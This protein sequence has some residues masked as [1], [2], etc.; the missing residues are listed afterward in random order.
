MQST[1]LTLLDRLCGPVPERSAWERFVELYTPLLGHWARQRGF[2]A[3]DAE[4]L[5]QELFV[6]LLRR[7]PAYERREAGS[8]RGWL[9]Y[10]VRTVAGQ[11]RRARA[12]RPLPT[13]SPASDLEEADELSD[14]EE[15]EFRKHLV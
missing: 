13:R 7:L 14:M 11:F 10:E 5:V 6:R 15:N 1:S 2:T 8:F 4:D 12:T 9:F 3:T